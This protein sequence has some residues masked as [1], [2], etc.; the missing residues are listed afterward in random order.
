MSISKITP[1]VSAL[2][3]VSLLLAGAACATSTA[4]T[5]AANAPFTEG[6]VQASY[7]KTGNGAVRVRVKN[8][9]DPK[10]LNAKATTY[11]IWLTPDGSPNAQNV[12]AFQVDGDQEGSFEFKTSF[13]KFTLNVSAEPAANALTMTGVSVLRADVVAE[14]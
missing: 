13:K 14:D 8:L 1:I 11:V 5:P 9:G 12:G 6:E 3:V 4:M 7:E 10:R 2:F